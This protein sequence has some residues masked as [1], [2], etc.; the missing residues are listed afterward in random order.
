MKKQPPIPGL[1]ELVKTRTR[2]DT[3]NTTFQ[4]QLKALQYRVLS[5][6]LEVL[7]LRL[8]LENSGGGKDA[9]CGGECD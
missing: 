5:L 7:L 3:K 9:H 1:E 8:Q 4:E 6:E 2:T